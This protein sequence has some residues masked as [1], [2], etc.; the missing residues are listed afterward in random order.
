MSSTPLVS[1]AQNALAAPAISRSA[2]VL[3]LPELAGKAMWR[4]D[5]LGSSTQ[6]DVVPTGFDL[7]DA[8]LPG[9][10]WPCRPD[11]HGARNAPQY[12]GLWPRE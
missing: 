4:G 1:P 11:R 9:G 8:E 10:G 5:E 2:D 7:L 6:R 3:R 12:A